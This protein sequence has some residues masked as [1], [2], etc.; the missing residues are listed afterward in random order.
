MRKTMPVSECM[1]RLPEEIDRRDR[2]SVAMRRMRERCVRHLPV[3]DGPHVFGVLSRDDV[4]DAWLMH[5]AGVE[6]WPVGDLCAR[7]PLMVSPGVPIPEVAQ[8]MVERGVT[9]A[10]VVDEGMLVGIFTSVDALRLL[11][12]L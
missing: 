7:A 2:L 12:D 6:S 10:L 3:M 9:S 4:E 1:S 11:A 8:C 5:G